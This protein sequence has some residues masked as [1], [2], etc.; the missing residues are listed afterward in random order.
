MELEEDEDVG[1]EEDETVDEVKVEDKEDNKESGA[2]EE[3]FEDSETNEEAAGPVSA[4]SFSWFFVESL[5]L[6]D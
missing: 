3:G 5:E 2:D 4:L 6:S 1:D